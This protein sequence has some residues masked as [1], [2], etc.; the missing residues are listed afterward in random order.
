M[1]RDKNEHKLDKMI[2]V[3][4][5]VDDISPDLLNEVEFSLKGFMTA[6]KERRAKIYTTQIHA[7][8]ERYL[9]AG[10]DIKIISEGKVI[11]ISDLLEGKNSEV[12]RDIRI[13]QNWEKMLLSGCFNINTEWDRQ[14]DGKYYFENENNYYLDKC[15]TGEIQFNSII[16]SIEKEMEE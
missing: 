11:L 6:W 13:T 5:S 16:N 2:V 1:Q 3:F 12:N 4:L 15:Y 14:D 8:S 9:Q 10:Y 7:I